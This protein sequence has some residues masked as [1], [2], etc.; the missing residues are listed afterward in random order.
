MD[1]EVTQETVQEETQT[2]N[3]IFTLRCNLQ[4]DVMHEGTVG[5]SV[6]DVP[7]SV[8][9]DLATLRKAFKSSLIDLFTTRAYIELLLISNTE[10]PVFINTAQLQSVEI[11]D[12][13]IN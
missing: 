9:N 4:H 12:L 6:E 7:V 2:V 5:L 11:L 8:V 13:N 10:Q 1:K 3:A